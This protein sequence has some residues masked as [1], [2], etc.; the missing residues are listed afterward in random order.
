MSVDPDD[1]LAFHWVCVGL[2]RVVLVVDPTPNQIL[3]D[4][5]LP[6]SVVDTLCSD[7]THTVSAIAGESGDFRFQDLSLNYNL[8]TNKKVRLYPA[9]TSEDPA[10]WDEFSLAAINNPNLGTP[11]LAIILMNF[12]QYQSAVDAPHVKMDWTHYWNNA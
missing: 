8:K 10:V 9:T 11:F 5:V 4:H 12:D 3:L 2:E 1:D 7:R 6:V